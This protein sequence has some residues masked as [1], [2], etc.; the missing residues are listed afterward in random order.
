MDK[1]T[2]RKWANLRQ[3]AYEKAKLS[4]ISAKIIADKVGTSATNIMN[5]IA[6]GSHTS[7]FSGKIDS[8]LREAVAEYNAELND[9]FESTGDPHT[10][11][12]NLLMA[13]G[14]LLRAASNSIEYKME[15]VDVVI[16]QLESFRRNYA[17]LAAR[18]SGE[19]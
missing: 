1:E 6:R 5:L 7:Q 15:I 10:E 18:D 12:G 2:Q 11:I 3:D 4:G 17:R 19:S 13:Q 16:Q 9:L 14:R 8:V